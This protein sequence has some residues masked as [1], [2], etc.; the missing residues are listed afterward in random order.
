MQLDYRARLPDELRWHQLDEFTL[1]YDRAA[2]Q[3][4]LL[5]APMPEL[6][7][8]LTAE[9]ESL[10]VIMARLNSRYELGDSE[11]AGP[12]VQAHLAELIMLGLIESRKQGPAD[13]A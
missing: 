5:A 9:W 3:T 11:N 6:L 2:G 12:A 4:H 1:I 8:C 7:E 10:A 13:A